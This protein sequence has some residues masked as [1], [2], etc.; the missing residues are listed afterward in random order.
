VE[1]GDKEWIQVLPKDLDNIE[2]WGKQNILKVMNIPSTHGEPIALLDSWEAFLRV[3][4]HSAM[5]DCISVDS[6]VGSL[7]N[8]MAGPN[9]ARAIPFF[10]HVCATLMTA[11]TS[12]QFSIAPN[13][14]A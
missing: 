4:T 13:K 10:Q 11:R 1:N 5:M 14:F 8:F 3:M 6:Y 12:Q 7:Y 2:F 9:G